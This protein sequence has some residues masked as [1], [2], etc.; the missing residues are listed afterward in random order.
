MQLFVS[1]LQFTR[2]EVPLRIASELFLER[3]ELS[4]EKL[5]FK[6]ELLLGCKIYFKIR[7]FRRSLCHPEPVEGQGVIIIMF[8][9]Q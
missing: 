9:Y 7:F 5:E 8:F 1:S 3:S 4:K 6:I 2:C